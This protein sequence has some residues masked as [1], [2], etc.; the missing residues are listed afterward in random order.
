MQ[1]HEIDYTI[2]G[3]EMQLVENTLDPAETVVAEAGAMTY[4][5]EDITFK[6]RMGTAP[7]PTKGSLDGQDNFMPRA[8][9]RP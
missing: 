6:T 8:M 1:S 7:I 2:I 4:M 5:E 3:A 9:L